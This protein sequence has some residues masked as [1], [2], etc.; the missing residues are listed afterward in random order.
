M[1]KIKESHIIK[2]TITFNPRIQNEAKVIAA[3]YEK[4]KFSTNIKE[5]LINEVCKNKQNSKDLMFLDMNNETLVSSLGILLYT[6]NNRGID[7][8]K[9]LLGYCN[10]TCQTNLDVEYNNNTSTIKEEIEDL[11]EDV[12]N[13]GIDLC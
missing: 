11:T 6:I 10:I 7:V 3:L 13:C 1:R 2:T 4:G 5:I 12:E 9:M 8:S